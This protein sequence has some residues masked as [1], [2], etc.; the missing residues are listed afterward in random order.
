QSTVID[1]IQTDAAVN[2]GNSGGALVNMDGELVGINSAIA[3][4]GSGSSGSIGLGF[5]IPVD[6]ARRIADQLIK[7]GFAT[8]AV[9]GVSVSDAPDVDGALVR[10]VEPGGPAERAGIR[11]GSV[12]SGVG[13]RLIEG[14]DALLAASRSRAPGDT[15]TVTYA[16]R[17]GETPNTV[18]VILGE[19][20]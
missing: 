20:R 13:E 17:E 7:Q 19:A 9:L 10:G 4:L 15:V 5:A 11:E 14:G 3:S 2:P 6:Q 1:A 8:R 12:I 16:S 18:D